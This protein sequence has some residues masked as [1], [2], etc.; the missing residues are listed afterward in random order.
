MSWSSTLRRTSSRLSGGTGPPARA[1][2]RLTALSNSQ[3]SIASPFTRARTSGMF[4][5]IGLSAAPPAGGWAPAG[6]AAAGAPADGAA[7]GGV[8]AAGV[9]VDAAEDEGAGA[10]RHAAN[11]AIDATSHHTNSFFMC[12]HD[13]EVAHTLLTDDHPP[14]A[15]N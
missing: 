4:A 14:R 3:R 10:L 8:A 2:T 5:G 6:A 12:V 7:A 13:S 9:A 11:P 1:S 15:K